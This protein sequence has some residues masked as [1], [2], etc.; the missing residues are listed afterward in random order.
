MRCPIVKE[1]SEEE[2]PALP[3]EMVD[4]CTSETDGWCW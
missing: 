1:V 3:V 4:S 2:E